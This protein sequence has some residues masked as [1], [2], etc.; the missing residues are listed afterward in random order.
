M[1]KE[2]KVYYDKEGDFLEIILE[3]KEGYFKET[4]NDFVMEKIDENGDVIGLSI[5]NI[6]SLKKQDFDFINLKVG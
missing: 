6:S 4:T 1:A 3:K 5:L 2:I